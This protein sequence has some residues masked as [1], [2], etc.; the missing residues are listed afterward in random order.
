M[1]GL[2]VHYPGTEILTNNSMTAENSWLYLQLLN[3]VIH[4]VKHI[5]MSIT[6]FWV[7]IVAVERFLAV[8]RPLKDKNRF[9]SYIGFV[10]IF[11]STINWAKFLELRVI[12][13][14]CGPGDR[15]LTTTRL[16]SIRTFIM[17]SSYYDQLLIH[18]LLLIVLMENPLNLAIW[19]SATKRLN[20]NKLQEERHESTS[21]TE[22]SFSVPVKTTTEKQFMTTNSGQVKWKVLNIRSSVIF[23]HTL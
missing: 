21:T 18:G 5:A 8:T 9:A 13:P 12:V 14:V 4:P 1:P 16:A 10:I 6:I 7:V 22:T 2:L 23:Y 11:S 15:S 20:S 3:T 17:W 19:F